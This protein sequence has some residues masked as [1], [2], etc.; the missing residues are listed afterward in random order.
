M[1]FG[2]VYHICNNSCRLFFNIIVISPQIT[3]Y[4]DI[5]LKSTP[6]PL[7]D[8]STNKNQPLGYAKSEAEKFKVEARKILCKSDKGNK[9]LGPLAEN[10]KPPTMYGLPKVHKEGI[11]MRPITSGIGSAP[12]K[13]AKCLAK[14]FSKIL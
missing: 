7:S 10:P 14:L 9:L 5:W 8:S 6:S 4:C 11:P 3:Q 1:I 12:H 2:N 13:L